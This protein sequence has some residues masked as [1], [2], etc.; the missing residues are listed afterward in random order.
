[1]KLDADKLKELMTT[2]CQGNYNE[3]A[4]ETKINV[5]ILHGIINKK[6]NAGMKTINLFIDFCKQKNIDYLEYIF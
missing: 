2:I 3:F 4:R 6:R 5:S 1:M